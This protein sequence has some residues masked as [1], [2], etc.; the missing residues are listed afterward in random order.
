MTDVDGLKA[1]LLARTPE[2]LLALFGEYRVGDLRVQVTVSPCCWMYPGYGLQVEY[3]T[4]DGASHGHLQNKK[5][6]VAR[7][8]EA[9]K[10]ADVEALLARLTPARCACGKATLLNP[11]DA[12]QSYDRAG[13]CE[14]C[15]LKRLREEFA[16]EDEQFQQELAR[17]DKKRKKQGYTHR[18][19]AWVHAGGD[20]Q[21]VSWYTKGRPTDAQV[22]AL[23]KR[24]RSRVLDDYK[25][26]EL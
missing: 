5:L 3:R 10:R 16:R 26:V 21:E 19:D 14:P 7:N 13:T 11:Q 24:R 15:F 2:G 12:G 1:D 9:A 23:L 25:V 18:I 6:D 8:R 20:D 22:K 4:P 17:E